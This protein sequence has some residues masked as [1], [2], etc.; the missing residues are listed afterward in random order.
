M[1]EGTRPL[2]FC[3]P[4]SYNFDYNLA[5]VITTG[6]SIAGLSDSDPLLLRQEVAGIFLEKELG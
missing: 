2:L 6:P 3:G 5:S 4:R 1:P